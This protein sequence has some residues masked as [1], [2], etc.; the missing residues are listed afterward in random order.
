[1]DILPNEVESVQDA[2]HLFDSTVKLLKTAGGLFLAVG[3]KKK[4][5]RKTEVLAAGSHAAIVNHQLSKQYGSDFEPVIAKSENDRL[6][7]VRENTSFLPSGAIGS[8]LELF[9]LSKNENV[10]FVLYKH[11]LSLVEYDGEIK[12]DTLIV[13]NSQIDRNLFKSDRKVAE[14]ISRSMRDKAFELNLKRIEIVK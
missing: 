5:S 4:N 12:N 3:K 9:T 6:E 11:G 13:K 8:G 1:M 14:A 10:K 7:D 2:G